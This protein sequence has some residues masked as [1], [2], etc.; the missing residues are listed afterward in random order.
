MIK[1]DSPFVQINPALI[2]DFQLGAGVLLNSFDVTAPSITATNIIAAT[3]GGITF[4][5]TPTVDDLGSDVDN[6]PEKTVELA[7]ISKYDVSLATTLL[8]LGNTGV[9]M[10]L[11]AAD[12]AEN[13][14]AGNSTPGNSTPGVKAYTP[15]YNLETTDFQTMWWL[16]GLVDGRY[17]AAQLL[18]GFNTGGFSLKTTKNG[19]GQ[20][21]ITI[22][23]FNTVSSP[24]VIPAV[25]YLSTGIYEPTQ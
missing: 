13:S 21:A 7:Y 4:N 14:P 17:L 5:I 11:G 6:C 9:T 12:M 23:G 8:N 16:G 18:R 19:K 20:T 2:N 15:R 24:S 22:T 3:T 25:V 1:H 10:A